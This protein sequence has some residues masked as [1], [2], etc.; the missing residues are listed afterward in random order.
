MTN[1]VLTLDSLVMSNFKKIR[2][3]VSEFHPVESTIIGPNGSGKSTHWD[4]WYW[5]FT[6]YDLE[7]RFNDELKPWLSDA[8]NTEPRVVVSVTGNVTY[9]GD[10]YSLRKE[11]HEVWGPRSDEEPEDVYQSDTVKYWINDSPIKTKKEWE[12][13]LTVFYPIPAFAAVTNPDYFFRMKKEDM[14][15][16]I[17]D[18]IGGDVTNQDMV[19]AN[20]DY[21]KLVE[22]VLKTRTIDQYRKEVRDNIKVNQEEQ[23]KLPDLI[24]GKQDEV[25]K[26]IAENDFDAT[27]KSIESKR[28]ELAEIDSKIE[29]A[30]N[31]EEGKEKAKI[32]Q[33]IAD[34]EADLA[35]FVQTFKNN[36]TNANSLLISDKKLLEGE[37]A[38]KNS[39]INRL[40]AD[41]DAASTKVEVLEKQRK[42]KEDEW[43]QVDKLQF[44]PAE[45]FVNQE[46]GPECDHCKRAF[47]L[48]EY[49]G[50]EAILR[51]AFNEEKKSKKAVITAAGKD[52]KEKKESVEA[53]IVAWEKLITDT[54]LEI[55]PL[56]EKLS[57]IKLD[58]RKPE[59][60]PE[61]KIKAEAVALE[62]LKLENFKDSDTDHKLADLTNLRSIVAGEIDSLNRLMGKKDSIQ[63]INKS[64]AE[65]EAKV[66]V[67]NNAVLTWKKAD[68]LL[69]SF[70]RDRA[71]ILEGRVNALF[72]HMKFTMFS[73]QNDGTPEIDC[74]PTYQGTSY[75]AVNTG[76]LPMLYVDVANAFA[77]QYKVA[78]PIFLDNMESVGKRPDTI[79]Q[80]INIVFPK[81]DPNIKS[82]Q[83][84]EGEY[85]PTINQ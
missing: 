74:I 27:E 49:Q 63:I 68:N 47:T 41:I 54:Q 7:R 25:A 53:Q 56:D 78:L 20:P 46:N 57:K 72:E 62:K 73:F 45:A 42:G 19:E 48:E 8:R 3:Q 23:K 29:A 4:A 31:T 67:I 6:G 10:K 85:K 81:Y 61:Y 40:K 17:I 75:P 55:V 70:L 43:Y 22:T 24:K 52:F 79:C 80:I 66:P 71:T 16:V 11:I 35:R 5:L 59:D 34:L 39:L 18:L 1:K 12:A 28:T 2:H 69:N 13:R 51:N 30:N 38:N 84:V 50:F 83:I 21:T 60:D 76:F 9:D 58:E 36:R 26:I 15:K 37:I 65:L 32:S 33:T 14:R 77:K 82:I 64:V 44:L